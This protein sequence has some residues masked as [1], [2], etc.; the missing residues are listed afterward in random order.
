MQDRAVIYLKFYIN[1]NQIGI[2]SNE[3]TSTGTSTLHRQLF[4][5][6]FPT[7]LTVVIRQIA[8]IPIELMVHYI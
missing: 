1:I 8:V 5:S 7:D 4:E 6:T 2:L 3:N